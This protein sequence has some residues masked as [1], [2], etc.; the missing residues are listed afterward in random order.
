MNL[1]AFKAC[2]KMSIQ[3]DPAKHTK[4]FLLANV[5][6]AIKFAES[7]AVFAA[8]PLAQD[9]EVLS[10]ADSSGNSIA[11]FLA[12]NQLAWA[13]TE[14]A[15]RVDV[16]KIANNYGNSVAHMLAANQSL[17]FETNAA[18]RLDVLSI[19]CKSGVSVAHQLVWQTKNSWANTE[20]AQAKEVLSMTDNQGVPVANELAI[21]RT[22]WAKTAAAQN[23]EV[24]SILTSEG[25]SVAH[26]LA[27]TQPEWM[28]TDGPL[29]KEVIF[30]SYETRG[31]VAEFI[32]NK[33]NHKGEFLHKMATHGISYK[34]QQN[35]KDWLRPKFGVD[36]VNSFVKLSS[37][38]ICDETCES[39]KLKKLVLFYS[40]CKNLEFDVAP[41]LLESACVFAKTE[42]MS[43]FD[44]NP[45]LFDDISSLHDVNCEPA[46]ELI[47]HF[48]SEKT[49]ANI[50]NVEPPASYDE[51]TCTQGLY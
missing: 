28:V 32:L 40:T 15:Q 10:R 41:E 44:A 30:L 33:S 49:F 11:Y 35:T 12:T 34:T 29:S 16:L 3:F 51:P 7:S 23:P 13:E 48:V 27:A 36:D 9:F 20:A 37:E 17:W 2:I 31:S 38:G 47:A 19:R 39:V 5:V 8:H 26:Q 1:K 42:I 4:E 14:A 22:E 45:A 6:V 25:T 50:M 24:L 43:L 46:M 18:Q 21:Y